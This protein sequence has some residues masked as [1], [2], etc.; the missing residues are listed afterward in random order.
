MEGCGLITNRF[1]AGNR[2]KALL[3]C[4]WN[5]VGHVPE[6]SQMAMHLGWPRGSVSLLA[7][8]WNYLLA[9]HK[10]EMQKHETFD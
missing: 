6:W 7:L 1:I 5:L 2:L 9:L 4:V 3:V 10:D 8:G